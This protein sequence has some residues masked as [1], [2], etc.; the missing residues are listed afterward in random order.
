[1]SDTADNFDD[2]EDVLSSIRRLVSE[3]TE[4]ATPPT[5]TGPAPEKITR[6]RSALVL[7]SEQRVDRR[8]E[9]RSKEDVLVQDVMA[10]AG[11]VR[12]DTQDDVDHA[13]SGDAA[14]ITGDDAS[15]G[16]G[17][18]NDAAHDGAGHEVDGKPM[19]LDS[20]RRAVSGAFEEEQRAFLTEPEGATLV[21]NETEPRR[22]QDRSD[23]LTGIWPVR[24]PEDYYE[25]ES[26]KEP[27]IEA[28][29]EAWPEPEPDQSEPQIDEP[30]DETDHDHEDHDRA[31][32]AWLDTNDAAPK[33]EDE[34]VPDAEDVPE[35]DAWFDPALEPGANDPAQTAQIHHFDPHMT[36]VETGWTEDGEIIDAA[37]I[38]AVDAAAEEE[39]EFESA[40]DQNGDD[41]DADSPPGIAAFLEGDPTQ[42]VVEDGIPD[43]EIAD[44][45]A[46]AGENTPEP[47]AQEGSMFAEDYGEDED[48]SGTTILADAG[49]AALM[50]E[51][52]LRELVAEI[53]RQELTGDMGERITR[54]VRKLVRREI[55]RALMTREF[56]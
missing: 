12:T 48:M 40:D 7:T 39:M 31:E 21:S 25:D 43:A 1:M 26:E 5:A 17:A 24:P 50:D 41:D 34:P 15:T 8:A 18:D 33:P 4:P 55:H 11:A 52:A 30:S 54:N 20:L 23:A 45:T 42:T 22:G 6:V 53:V 47:A 19:M 29:T 10:E 9:D 56:D 3:T 38:V 27:A 46:E 49:D 14:S 36:V 2:V 32:Q 28:A 13:E 51:E 16:D 44:D 35:A 37:D